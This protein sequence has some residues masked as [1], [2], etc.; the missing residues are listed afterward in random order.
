MEVMELTKEEW[1][2]VQ[3]RLSSLFCVVNLK[4]DGYNVALS[5]TRISTYKNAIAVY[6]DGGFRGKWLIEDCEERRRFLQKRERSL[7]SDKQMASIKK[8]SKKRQKEFMEKYNTKYDTYS[9]HWT[10]FGALKKHLI[11]NNENIELVS[12]N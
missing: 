6:V 11:A 4:I 1:I 7:L 8:L 10:S 5:L 3:E 2:K 12:I 9:S